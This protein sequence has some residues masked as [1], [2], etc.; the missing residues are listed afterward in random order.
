[1]TCSSLYLK[2]VER[3]GIFAKHALK[4]YNFVTHL[5][6]RNI[7]ALKNLKNIIQQD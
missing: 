7:G 4:K 1:M 5:Q 3:K 2:I 6:K